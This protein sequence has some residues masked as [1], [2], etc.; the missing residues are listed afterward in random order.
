MNSDVATITRLLADRA[1]DVCRHYLPAGVREGRYWMVGDV[2]NT[3]GRSMYVRL[4][5]SDGGGAGKWTDAESGEYGDLLDL[6]AKRCGHAQFRD[7]LEE[8]RRFL[9]LPQLTPPPSQRQKRERAPGGTP[10]AAGRLFKASQPIQ[11]TLAEAYLRR[12]G[13]SVPVNWSALRYHPDCYYRPGRADAPSV[14]TSWPAMIAAIT[15][16]TGAITAVLRTWLDPGTVSKAPV[17]SPRRSL[18]HVLGHGIRFGREGR[19]MIFGEGVETVASLRTIMPGVGMI[20]ATSAAHLAAVR[21][22]AALRHLIVARDDDAAG[23]KAYAKLA[24]RA[25]EAGISCTP[26]DPIRDDFNADLQRL[27]LKQFR[28]HVRT[29]LAE[30]GAEQLLGGGSHTT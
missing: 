15:D 30:A 13:I 5:G 12:R 8:A 20:A 24:Q 1:E 26:L 10:E 9:A 2:H 6:I 17:A 23:A 28:E 14:R 16:D 19:T 18:G 22:P 27:G 4:S 3:P 7:T 29:R 21:F 25:S 11:S